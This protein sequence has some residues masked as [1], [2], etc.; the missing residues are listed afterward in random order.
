MIQ[1]EEV[2]QQTNIGAEQCVAGRDFYDQST[3]NYADLRLYMLTA[4]ESELDAIA[5]KN[6][7][8][9]IT[10]FG[11]DYNYLIRQSIVSIKQCQN[12]TARE[13]KHLLSTNAIS[14]NKDKNTAK[15][16]PDPYIYYFGWLS[17]V[18]IFVQTACNLYLVTYYSH[19]PAW[20]L[21]LA[22]LTISAVCMAAL[23]LYNWVFI[24]PYH[25][26]KRSHSA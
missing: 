7:D 10:R 16:N 5:I 3:T 20:R 18:F 2:M 13:T 19:N 26:L 9:F 25:I 15:L 12:Y 8:Y 14:V 22:Q 1:V 21:T 6:G 17:I 4:E 11:K 23:W 24:A